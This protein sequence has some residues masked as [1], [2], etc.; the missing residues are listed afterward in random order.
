MSVE[1]FSEN[2][3]FVVVFRSYESR[4]N[5]I[6]LFNG[7]IYYSSNLPQYLTK[8]IFGDVINSDL[9]PI[10]PFLLL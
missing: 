4:V 8:A 6:E 7:R 3:I 9:K 2:F 10:K 1:Y 5:P